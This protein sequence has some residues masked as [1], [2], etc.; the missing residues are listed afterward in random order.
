MD[1]ECLVVMDGCHS[2]SNL[3]M[4]FEWD[5]LST[6]PERASPRASI[7]LLAGCTRGGAD[8]EYGVD[9]HEQW[10]GALTSAMLQSLRPGQTWGQLVEDVRARLRRCHWAIVPLLAS[11]TPLD[12]ADDFP[13]VAHA[14]AGAPL[15]LPEHHEWIIDGSRFAL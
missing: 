7:R 9:R 13:F 8:A 12:L 5:P 1:S 10:A 2:G 6:P 4:P 11:S 15:E 14:S 3:E